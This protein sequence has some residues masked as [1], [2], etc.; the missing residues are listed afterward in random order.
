MKIK[1]LVLDVDGTLTDGKIYIGADG[2]CMKAF[3]VK[4]GYGIGVILPAHGIKTVIMTGRKSQIVLNRAKELGIPYVLQ[5]V[6]DKVE[7]IQQLAADV[8]SEFAEIAYIGD[9]LNDLEAMK[10]CGVRG[11]P[12]D[13]A[14]EIKEISHYISGKNGGD[15]AV[16]DFIEW[17]VAQ[18]S[19]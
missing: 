5:G 17:T 6:K 12:A 2:E 11:C 10:L 9:D 7:A 8:E 18:I 15:G 14:R 1:V 13:A 16:R 19:D 3:N 4:D